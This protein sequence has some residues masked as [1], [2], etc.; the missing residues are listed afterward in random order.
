MNQQLFTTHVFTEPDGFTDGIE[1]P[2]CDQAGNLYAVNYA[3]QHTIGKITPAGES[4]IF[5]EL[6]AGSIGNGIV[7]NQSDEM[8]IA[9]YTG[10]NVLKVDMQRRQVSVFAHEPRMHQPNDLAIGANGII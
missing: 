6:S 2:A 4:S 1:G 3:R 8:F 7:F 9:D 5:L 10:H